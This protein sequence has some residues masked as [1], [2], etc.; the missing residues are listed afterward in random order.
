M[1]RFRLNDL[2]I[3]T[4]LLSFALATF[5]VSVMPL[6]LTLSVFYMALSLTVGW[7]AWRHRK[8]GWRTGL[9]YAVLTLTIPLW[10]FG[11]FWLS[12]WLGLFPPVKVKPVQDRLVVRNS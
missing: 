12:Q 6:G 5:I 4:G 2:F 8:Q 10:V 7:S 11:A 1:P 3:G 9:V